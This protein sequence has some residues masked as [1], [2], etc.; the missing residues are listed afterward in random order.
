ML[1]EDLKKFQK[2]PDEK[3]FVRISADSPLIDYRIIK[4]ML[5]I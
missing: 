2:S 1:Q 3:Y 4:K 5:K